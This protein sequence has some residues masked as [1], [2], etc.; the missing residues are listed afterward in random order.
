L[1]FEFITVVLKVVKFDP[2]P[3]GGKSPIKIADSG[4]GPQWSVYLETR[5]PERPGKYDLRIGTTEDDSIKS[6]YSEQVSKRIK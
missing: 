6:W 1:P 4:N 3:V 2:I 5:I